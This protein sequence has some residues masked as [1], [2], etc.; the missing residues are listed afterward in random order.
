MTR[1]TTQNKKTLKNQGFLLPATGIE[2]VS[3]DF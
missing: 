2:P 1:N 3:S